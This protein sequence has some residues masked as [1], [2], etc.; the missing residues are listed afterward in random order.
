MKASETW[1]AKLQ[2]G[3]GPLLHDE[4]MEIVADLEAAEV[5]RKNIEEAWLR[6]ELPLG[7]PCKM[8]DDALARAEK[9]EAER[10]V[11]WDRMAVHNKDADDTIARAE[12]ESAGLREKLSNLH[13]NYDQISKEAGDYH[14]KYC[15]QLQLR[16]DDGLEA[17][18]KC[19]DLEKKIDELKAGLKSAGKDVWQA[20]AD[21]DKAEAERDDIQA[22]WNRWVQ[23]N[24]TWIADRA[25]LAAALRKYGRHKKDCLW[26]EGMPDIDTPQRCTCGF[27]EVLRAHPSLPA[28][29]AELLRRVEG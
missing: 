5:A 14:A 19:N 26:H 4:A 9:A 6:G 24:S 17:S 22:E 15:E 3:M 28:D 10:K 25:A 20:Q 23:I 21:R 8:L 13:G 16:Q 18:I 12:A 29:V 27:E 7:I 2:I 11:A 1:A